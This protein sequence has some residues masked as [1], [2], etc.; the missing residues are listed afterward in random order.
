LPTEA[1]FEFAL[2]GGNN[3]TGVTFPWGNATLPSPMYGNYG[4]EAAGRMF[5]GWTIFNG[6]DDGY[7]TTSPVCAFQ[8]NPYGLCDISGNCWEWCSDWYAADYYQ[9]SP[10][11]NPPGPPSGQSHVWRGGGWDS[12]PRGARVY[13]RMSGSP[14][15]GSI[16]FRCVKDAPSGGAH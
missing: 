4:D 11:N 16:G 2:R 9:N 14:G 12:K 10:P 15:W 7:A 5:N 13:T 6:Y 1:E 3:E 8:R